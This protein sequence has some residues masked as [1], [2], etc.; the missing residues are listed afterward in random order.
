MVS[1]YEN[2]PVYI[3]VPVVREVLLRFARNHNSFDRTRINKSKEV[4]HCI[5]YYL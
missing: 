4:L 5:V 1:K 3:V 2:T